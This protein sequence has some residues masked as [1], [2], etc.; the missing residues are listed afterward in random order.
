MLESYVPLSIWFSNTTAITP[1]QK[2]DFV[3]LTQTKVWSEEAQES[4]SKME[5]LL[6]A[7]SKIV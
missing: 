6:K 1:Q 7:I 5:Q 4:I 3:R 2:S